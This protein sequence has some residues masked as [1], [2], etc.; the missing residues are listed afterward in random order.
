MPVWTYVSL[1][2]DKDKFLK[3]APKRS[4][5]IKC[6]LVIEKM[7]QTFVCLRTE[8]FFHMILQSQ[9]KTFC[10]CILVFALSHIYHMFKK[11]LFEVKR[12]RN[13]S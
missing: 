4:E 10:T 6:L 1:V 5:I 2:N 8:K 9:K 12:I 7:H 11:K 3:G 13:S